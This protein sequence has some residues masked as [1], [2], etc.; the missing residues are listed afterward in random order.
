MQLCLPLYP[1]GSLREAIEA[2]LAERAEYVAEATILDYSERARWCY[3]AF[4][5]FAPLRSITYERMRAVERE[6]GPKGKGLMLVTV[7]KRLVFLH[8]ALKLAA[9]RGIIRLD[10]VPPVPHIASDS[11]RMERFLTLLEY[12]Q[13]RGALVG[14][15]R[16]LVDLAF[17][18]GQHRRELWTMKRWMLEPDHVWLD[19]DGQQ[20]MW[21]GRWWRRNSKNKRCVPC[22][23][24]AEPEF[25]PIMREILAEPGSPESLVVGR[26]CNYARSLHAA[27]DRLEMPPVSLM[28]MRHSLATLMMERT[29]DYEQV[30]AVLGHEGP[31]IVTQQGRYVGAADPS[32]LTRHYLATSPRSMIAAMKRPRG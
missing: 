14:R 6:W 32:I 22:W 9:A 27:C 25:L 13:L 5:E 20:T 18:T 8:A 30:R 31:P 16:T 28:A 21:R 3:A 26:V 10:E 17:W 23:L 7:K 12:Q 24:P 4:G 11:R 2:Y 29:G 1:R 15:M 19:N